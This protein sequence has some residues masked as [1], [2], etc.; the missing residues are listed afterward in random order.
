MAKVIQVDG[1]ELEVAD[2]EECPMH[3][4]CTHICTHPERASSDRS[5]SCVSTHSRL[6]P[7]KNKDGD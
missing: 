3:R 1:V 4:E 5:P 6:C 7:L 2:Y